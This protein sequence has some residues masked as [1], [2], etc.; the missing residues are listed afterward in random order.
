MG[1]RRAT[2]PTT[3]ALGRVGRHAR[4]NTHGT[5][6]LAAPAMRARR[7]IHAHPI[8]AELVEEAIQGTK[9]AEVLAK[10]PMDEQARHQDDHKYEHFP[11]EEE[12]RKRTKRR[13]GQKQR[14]ARTL[15]G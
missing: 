8:E 13:V 1:A 4:I 6:S 11:A 10:R 9:R 15:V 7:G 5:N 3:D 12:A 2:C 14:N